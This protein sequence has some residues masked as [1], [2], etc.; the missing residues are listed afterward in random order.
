MSNVETLSHTFI[1]AHPAD[2]ARVLEHLS[3]EASAEL[4]AQ[5]PARVLAPAVRAMMPFVAAQAVVRLSPEAAA[6]LLTECG[7]GSGAAIMR[8]VP[9]SRRA[10]LL[11]ALPT[12]TAV[13]LRLLL[14]FPA[15][16]VGAWIDSGLPALPANT[17]VG[18]ALQRLRAGEDDE[19]DVVHVVDASQRLLGLVELA[20]LLRAGEHVA[21]AHL[22]Q[23]VRYVL[24]VNA[25]L[26]SVQRHAGWDERLSLP[27]VERDGRLAG[28]LR[29]AALVQALAHTRREPHT[30]SAHPLTAIEALGAGYWLA[31]DEL[32]QS[33]IA[34]FPS[35]E[36]V[37]QRPHHG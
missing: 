21:L 15:S 22:M 20:A 36:P 9:E 28:V 4:F 24:P 2:A 29:R 18:A 34:L 7:G 25:T 1:A 32:M 23:D 12:T 8:Y 16:S 27:A 6:H 19:I 13:S 26:A 31:I 35:P 10:A 33:V 3:P 5:A 17:T 11:E 30:D 14:G 37:R